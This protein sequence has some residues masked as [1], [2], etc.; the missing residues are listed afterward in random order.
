MR[1]DEQHQR[2]RA[3]LVLLR[4]IL[5]AAL[6]VLVALLTAPT[7]F[8]GS[9]LPWQP[10]MVDLDVYRR[11]GAAVLSGQDLYSAADPALPFLYPPFSAVLSVPLGLLPATPVQIGWLV[12][13]VLALLAVLHR[14]GLSGWVLSL[15]T[16]GTIWFVEPVRHTLAYGQLGIFLVA[17]V[18]LDLV[19]GPRLLSARR[20]LPAGVLAGLGAAIKLT[21]GIFVPFLLLVRDRA[22]RVG[23]VGAIAGFGGCTLLGTLVLPSASIGYWSRLATGDSGTESYHYL[24][25]QAVLGSWLRL[26]GLGGWQSASGMVLAAAVA[27]LG[28]WAG[29]LL[30]RR[31]ARVPLS[32]LSSPSSLNSP[33]SRWG[34]SDSG[35]PIAAAV[36]VVGVA[37]LLAS[38]IS[39]SHHFVW[40]LPLAVVL[41]RPAL[42]PFSRP[43]Q[44]AGWLFVAWVSAA[45]FMMLPAG[46]DVELNYQPWQLLL[47]SVTPVLGIAF[48]IATLASSSPASPP[49]ASSAIR[50]ARPKNETGSYAEVSVARQPRPAFGF[51]PAPAAGVQNH[52]ASTGGDDGGS[53]TAQP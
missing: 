16:A 46:S 41:A 10:Q 35:T 33:S 40:V 34:A 42:C 21:P 20:W 22:A 49:S 39:W 6:P 43:A 52:E 3:P 53:E 31:T 28:L 23:A 19:P 26:V 14:L 2:R 51:A 13:N 1:S 38:P 7:A 32:S 12:L 29:V 9:V 45:P 36:C 48:L 47:V 25:N 11:A 15:V 8:G 17:L 30:V 18:L 50:T 44:V 27:A 37:G 4:L 24:T 5:V